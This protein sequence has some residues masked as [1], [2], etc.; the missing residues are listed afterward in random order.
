MRLT[1]SISSLFFDQR[2]RTL[3]LR[4]GLRGS[5]SH[6]VESVGIDGVVKWDLVQGSRGRDGVRPDIRQIS[7]EAG[8]CAIRASYTL[9]NDKRFSP[10]REEEK[11]EKEVVQ[12]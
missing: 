6:F 1:V 5:R 3:L 4:L 12:D 9:C 10:S 2:L 8:C 7:I 11:R